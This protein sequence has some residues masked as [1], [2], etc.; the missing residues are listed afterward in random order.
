MGNRPN[1]LTIAGFDPSSGAGLTADIKTFESLKCYGLAV[2]TA[3]TIQNDTD[4]EECNWVGVEVIKSQIS[5]LFKKF[6]IDYVK[7]GIIQNWSVLNEIIDFLL[8]K[9]KNVKIILD[10]VLKSSSDFNFQ[11]Q[12]LQTESSSNV[13]DYKFEQ[14]LD[15]IYL[16]TPNYDEIEMFYTGRTI[17]ETVR[18]ISAKTNVLLKGGHR[19]EMLGKDELFTSKGKYF[20]LNPKNKNITEKHGSGCILSSAITAQ[21]ALGFTLLKSCFRGKRYIEK[22]LSS[23]TTLLGYHRI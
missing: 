5:I 20:V 6:N 1:I 11:K 15:K 16:L 21:L 13:L 10:P 22:V 19:K 17:N 8:E 12:S 23:N 2:C 7:I 9:N 18:H 14:I 3:N 4:F